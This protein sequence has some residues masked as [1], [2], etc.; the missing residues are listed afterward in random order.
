[1]YNNSIIIIIIM[2]LVLRIQFVTENFTVHVC[3]SQE[4]FPPLC[5]TSLARTLK[6][7]IQALGSRGQVLPDVHMRV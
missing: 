2:L 6:R 3:T 7:W 5:K 4:D 1:M